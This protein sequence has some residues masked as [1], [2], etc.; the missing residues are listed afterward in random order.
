MRRISR[1]MRDAGGSVPME[2]GLIAALVSI[3]VLYSVGGFTNGFQH[4]YGLV[5]NTMDN[6][7]P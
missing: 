6:S 2:Y 5:S 3:A 4:V 1:L 7:S